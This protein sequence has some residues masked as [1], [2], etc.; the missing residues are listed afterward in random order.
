MSNLVKGITLLLTILLLIAACGQEEPTAESQAVTP[1]SLSPTAAAKPTDLPLPTSTMVPPTRTATSAPT[2]TATAPA[3]DTPEPTS[4]P[5]PT[6][7]PY[8]VITGLYYMGGQDPDRSLSIYLPTTRRQGLTLLVMAGE[9]YPS[10]LRYFADLGYTVIAF[11]VR[12][13]TYQQFIQDGFCALAWA[14]AKADRYGFD[15]AGI[16]P[17]GGSM[18]GGIVALLGLIDDP[19]PFLEEC[20]HTLPETDRVRAV[21]AQA[22]VFDYSEEGDFFEGYVESIGTFMGGTP[23]QVPENWAAASAIT[24]VKGD[25][26][27]FLLVHGEADTN[28]APHQS[29]KFAAAL[30]EAGVDVEL[31]LLP[32]I[33]HYTSVTDRKVFEAMASYLARLEE[34][35]RLNA[36][37]AGTFAFVSNRD[38]DYEIYLKV[39]PSVGGGPVAEIQLTHNEASDL[40]PDWSP[41]GKRI[42]FA[43]TRDGNWDIYVMSVDDAIQDPEDAQVRRLTSDEGDDQSPVWSPDGTWIAFS[44]DRDGDSE[45]YV[46]RADGTDLRQLTDNTSIDSKP[47]W[48]PDGAKIAFD[49]GWGYGRDIFVMDADGANQELLVDVEGGWP[50]WSPDGTRIAYFDRVEGTSEIYVVNVDGTGRARLTLNSVGD[51]EPSWSPDGEWVLYVSGQVPDV[52][53]VRADGGEPYRLTND[54]FEDWSPAWRP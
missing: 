9:Y 23:E 28:V 10:M 50:A 32:G 30:E 3:T 18:G 5:T 53:M 20:P 22:G 40:V 27:P 11:N 45:I 16:I 44:S 1:S 49:S 24:W 34:A 54:S 38:G 19:T 51:W 26:P 25:E 36:I 48:S 46:M 42:A 4:T 21:I 39:L 17:V 52:F 47:S 14:H 35:D 41:D 6:I 2:E 15:A 13:D 8:E 7:Q 31:V 33:N 29:E 37:G 12:S 43:S